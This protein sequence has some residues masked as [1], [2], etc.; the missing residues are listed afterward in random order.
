MNSVLIVSG[1]DN[2]TETLAAL[3]KECGYAQITTVT[4]GALARRNLLQNSYD[5]VIINSP[6]SD[7]FGHAIAQN[8]YE[9]S[10]A[11]CIMIVKHEMC[12]QVSA[13]VEEYGAMVVSKPLNKTIFHQ[14]LKLCL[15]SKRRMEAMQNENKRLMDK[16]EEM[17]LVDR[18]KC[19]LIQY[20]KLT[21]PQAHRYIEKQA[22]DMRETKREIALR[23]IKTY[24]R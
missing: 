1:N 3:I 7:E 6:L 21:E 2:A 12:D 8:I 17:R 19:A 18:A 24:E 13:K 14:S 10:D 15:A 4:S 16:I 5:V 22:M 23:V 11:S 9:T 20:L